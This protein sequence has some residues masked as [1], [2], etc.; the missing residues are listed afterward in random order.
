MR[1]EEGGGKEAVSRLAMSLIASGAAWRKF[2]QY[3]S[4]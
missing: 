1:C 2:D 4:L 3:F